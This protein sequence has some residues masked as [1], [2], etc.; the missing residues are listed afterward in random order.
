[1]TGLR[2]AIVVDRDYGTAAEHLLFHHEFVPAGIAFKVEITITD[3][4][5]EIIAAVLFALENFNNEEMKLGCDSN[6][7]WG[8]MKWELKEILMFNISALPEWASRIAPDGAD[9]CEVKPLPFVPVAEKDVC[10]IRA[11]CNEFHLQTAKRLKFKISLHFANG[12][13]I[14][15]YSRVVKD[16]TAALMPLIDENGNPYLSAKSARGALRSQAEK[17]IRTVGGK[18]CMPHI[19]PCQLDLDRNHHPERKNQ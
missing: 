4:T 16:K 8:K 14:N 6:N 3:A 19:D 11:L 9:S 1:M 5:D 13:M 10:S 7:G 12:F 17:I 18:A 15:D 2:T